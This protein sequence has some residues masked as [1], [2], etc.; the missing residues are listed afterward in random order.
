MPGSATG[1]SCL[2]TPLLTLCRPD[3]ARRGQKLPANLFTARPLIFNYTCIRKCIIF[4]KRMQTLQSK[5]HFDL[6]SILG[7][8]PHPQV[9][10]SG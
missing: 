7:P 1:W 9:I 2:G 8:V 3:L 5:D 6:T 4:V 10:L